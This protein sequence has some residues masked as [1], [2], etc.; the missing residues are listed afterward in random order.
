MHTEVAAVAK[1]DLSIVI[2]V[3][4]AATNETAL[5]VTHDRVSLQ[6]NISLL[7]NLLFQ[8]SLVVQ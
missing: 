6:Q 5:I 7:C 3:L 8:I 4:G 2:V 1:A